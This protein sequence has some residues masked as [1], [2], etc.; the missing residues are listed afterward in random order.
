GRL[1]VV[2]P[3]RAQVAGVEQRQERAAGAAARVE[4][5]PGTALRAIQPAHAE[6]DGAQAAIPPMAPLG[7]VHHFVFVKVHSVISTGS[8][9]SRAGRAARRWPAARSQ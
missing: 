3:L 1:T 2:E 5:A 7:L 8:G 6:H 4:D 9:S